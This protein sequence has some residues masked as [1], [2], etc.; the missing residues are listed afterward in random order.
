MRI[1]S[2]CCHIFM[3]QICDSS[4]HSVTDRMEGPNCTC[5][6]KPENDFKTEKNL[7]QGE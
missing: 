4:I 1:T 7:L 5:C 3:K 6:S 2:S